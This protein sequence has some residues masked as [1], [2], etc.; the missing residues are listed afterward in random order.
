MLDL[1]RKQHKEARQ[2]LKSEHNYKEGL[3]IIK[4]NPEIFNASDIRSFVAI[5]FGEK[6]T[7]ILDKDASTLKCGVGTKPGS[8]CIKNKCLMVEL[9]VHKDRK[10]L[11]KKTTVKSNVDKKLHNPTKKITLSKN[12][13]VIKKT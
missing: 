10:P 12:L 13:G 8:K 11:E 5:W 9:C 2:L 6:A 7:K 1:K 4:D 3:S